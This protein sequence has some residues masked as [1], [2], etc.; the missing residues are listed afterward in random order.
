MGTM[1][2]MNVGGMSMSQ[3]WYG[4][5]NVQT[6]KAPVIMLVVMAALAVV[7]PAI[8][9]ARIRPGAHP[10]RRAS[11]RSLRC[12]TGEDAGLKL[13]RTAWRNLWRHP[14]RRDRP[15]HRRRARGGARRRTHGQRRLR[16]GQ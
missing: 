2:G 5:Y 8:K 14:A 10:P 9:A 15:G 1:G 12:V 16:D 13:P 4:I 11:A 3:V 7:Y 6:V